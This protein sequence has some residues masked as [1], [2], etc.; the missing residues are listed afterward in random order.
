[1]R[2]FTLSSSG[3]RDRAAPLVDREV[4]AAMAALDSGTLKGRT[5]ALETVCFRWYEV[6]ATLSD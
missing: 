3:D 1:M 5:K 6:E 4:D 2:F